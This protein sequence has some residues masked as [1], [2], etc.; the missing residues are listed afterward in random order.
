[1]Q[2]TGSTERR[3]VGIIERDDPGLNHDEVNVAVVA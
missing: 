1:M 2:D 3:C